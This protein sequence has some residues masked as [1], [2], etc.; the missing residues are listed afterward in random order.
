MRRFRTIPH[1]ADIGF[2]AYGKNIT[3]AFSNS[4]Y[5]FS[6]AITSKKVISTRQEKINLVADDEKQALYRLLDALIQMFD[7][8]H[9]IPSE[10]IKITIKKQKNGTYLLL[11]TIWGD[12]AENYPLH[13]YIK[14]VT[15]SDMNI[16]HS[17]KG[18]ICTVILD[19]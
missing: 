4:V 2:Q 16:A 12:S 10:Q 17:K 1:T 15:Y 13:Q 8:K 7:E 9:F 3:E 18:V 5:A 19:I 11:S 14:A 6:R